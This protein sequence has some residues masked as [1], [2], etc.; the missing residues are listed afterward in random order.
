MR[1]GLA[2]ND[3]DGPTRF[4]ADEAE[5][6]V[7]RRGL[8]KGCFVAPKSFRQWDKTAAL[9]GASCRDDKTSELRAILFPDEPAM[10]PG[11]AIKAKLSARARLAG[12][13]GIYH[14]QSCRSY[15]T[16]TRPNRWFCSEE[17]AQA[18]GFRKPYNCRSKAARTP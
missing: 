10:P 5:A 11:C 3:P 13:I 1:E 8:W 4:A 17:D 2:F 6:R 16:V 12:K 14:L 9:L 18:A 7:N 15:A